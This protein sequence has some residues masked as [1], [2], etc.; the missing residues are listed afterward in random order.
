MPVVYTPGSHTLPM[1]DREGQVY[2]GGS[3]ASSGF[4][5]QAAWAPLSNAYVHAA[6]SWETRAIDTTD[7]FS[8]AEGG[9]GSYHRIASNMVV[10][11]AAA[12]GAGY[13][14]DAASEPYLMSAGPRSIERE[15]FGHYRR[16][17]GQ[18][19]LERSSVPLDRDPRVLRVGAAFAARVSHVT[20]TDLV[21][22]ARVTYTASDGGDSVGTWE[23]APAT[24]AS[25][26]FLEPVVVLRA[27]WPVAMLDY[28]IGWVV[29]FGTPDFDVVAVT[30]SLGL[31]LH[32]DRL[33]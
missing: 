9:V 22:R 17:Y 30:F 7:H 20:F 25:G 21:T 32:I 10:D 6:A 33:F 8:F 23:T 11:L 15:A 4:D 14:S 18:I 29:P 13:A 5:L 12:Y 26:T 31:H 1:F 28:R 16:L 27:G 3:V 2:A 19:A 24:S